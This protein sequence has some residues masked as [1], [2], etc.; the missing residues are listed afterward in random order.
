MKEKKQT[1]EVMS[2]TEHPVW[3]EAFQQPMKH[4]VKVIYWR[5]MTLAELQSGEES[6][7]YSTGL[8]KLCLI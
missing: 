4:S 2:W 3:L 6:R 1:R 7:V 5:G 8:M